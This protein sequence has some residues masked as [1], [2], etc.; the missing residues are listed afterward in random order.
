MKTLQQSGHTLRILKGV[1]LGVILSIVLLFFTSPP[2]PRGS[3]V[4][5]YFSVDQY[6]RFED[7]R[8]TEHYETG[9]QRTSGSYIRTNG[10]WVCSFESS[11]V[12][13]LRLEPSWFGVR[14]FDSTGRE[15]DN[16]TRRSFWRFRLINLFKEGT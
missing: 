2:S 9:G 8:I 7:G 5:Q 14:V 12:V 11:N 13:S 1:G 6:T 4:S 10:L 3:Y 15:L 16:M